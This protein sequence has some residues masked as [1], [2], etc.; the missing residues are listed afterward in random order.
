MDDDLDAEF[1]CDA[2]PSA[3]SLGLDP[4]RVNF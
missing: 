3:R 2:A 4:D 1:P